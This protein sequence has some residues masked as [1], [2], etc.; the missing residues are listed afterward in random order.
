MDAKRYRGI[1]FVGAV[2]VAVAV[3]GAAL[4]GCAGAPAKPEVN[5]NTLNTSAPSTQ[6]A[7]LPPDNGA[8]GVSIELAQLPIGGNTTEDEQTSADT[9]VTVNWIVQKVAAKIPPDAHIKITGAHFTSDEYALANSGCSGTYPQCIGFVFDSSHQICEL[10]IA[11]TE[12]VPGVD[13]VQPGV[14]ISGTV[15]CSDGRTAACASFLAAV[16]TEQNLTI[17]LDSPPPPSSPQGLG[18]TDSAPEA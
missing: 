3:C 16:A 17:P 10:A 7:S 1:S 9:C 4:S 14:G 2:L 15:T 13:D 18:T 5:P 6:S 8:A 11:A 12:S